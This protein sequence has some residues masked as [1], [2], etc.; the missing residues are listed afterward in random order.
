MLVKKKF[1]C[2][3]CVHLGQTY[4]KSQLPTLFQNVSHMGDAKIPKVD[5]SYNNWLS[6]GVNQNC[7]PWIYSSTLVNCNDAIWCKLALSSTGKSVSEALI[8]E[9]GNNYF[10]FLFWHSKQFLYATCS[11]H[12]LNLQFSWTICRHI[13]GKLI[14]E[15]VLLKKIY[16]YNCTTTFLCLNLWSCTL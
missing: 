5:G 16:L 7:F 10:L 2:P 14:K 1:W 12:V 15:W 4:Q 13:V 11:L 6:I 9:S 3:F 8:L